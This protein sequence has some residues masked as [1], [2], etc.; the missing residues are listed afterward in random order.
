MLLLLI[1]VAAWGG[2]NAARAAADSLR[3]LPS[4]NDDMVF[5]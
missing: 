3:S 4:R 1:L 2:W 5:W